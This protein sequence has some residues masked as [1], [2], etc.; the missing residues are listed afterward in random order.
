[1]K[2]SRL[3]GWL[4]YAVLYL[5]VRPEGDSWCNESGQCGRVVIF[6]SLIDSETGNGIVVVLLAVISNYVYK[7]S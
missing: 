6:N 3:N 7:L 4:F 1:M 2:K 5:C